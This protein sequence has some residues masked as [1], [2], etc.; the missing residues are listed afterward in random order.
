MPLPCDCCPTGDPQCALAPVPFDSVTQ[1]VAQAGWNPASLAA[2]IDGI[3]GNQIC[4]YNSPAGPTAS[5][6]LRVEYG[7]TSAHNR[8]RGLRLWNNGGSDLNDSDGLGAFN[9]EFYAGATLL[10]TLACLGVNGGTPLT[11]TLPAGTELNGV[12]RVVLR[13]LGK[14]S[15]STVSPLWREIQLLEYQPVFP[16]RRRNGTLEWY[17]DGGLLVPTADVDLCEPFTPFVLPDLRLVGSAF[18]DDPGGVAENL[19]NVSPAPSSTTGW[20][21]NG[22]CYDPIVGNPQ[23]N[24]A[25]LSSVTMEYGQCPAAGGSSGGV[26]VQLSSP[27]LAPAGITWPTNNQDMAVGTSRMSNPFGGG[28]RAILTY[29]SGPAAGSASGTIRMTGGINLGLHFGNVSA[30]APIRFRLDFV[31]A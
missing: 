28:R 13:D 7:L 27:S 22:T 9:A 4:G 16:C 12:T 18:G 29:L 11:F 30:A 14:L 17:T 19:M 21:V 20:T 23:M 10:T 31:N 1:T 6:T 3:M 15:G 5:T 2:T 24:W 8:V 26:F 25:P